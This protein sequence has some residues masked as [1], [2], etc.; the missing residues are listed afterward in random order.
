[1]QD[2]NHLNDLNNAIARLQL[3]EELPEPWNQPGFL[4]E[5]LCLTD[6]IKCYQSLFK[7]LAHLSL[8]VLDE[9][10]NLR[11]ELQ[12]KEGDLDDIKSQLNT[13]EAWIK[14]HQDGLLNQL[15][16]L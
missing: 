1:M 11:Y 4:V 3:A 16:F 7:T 10:E 13:I 14:E 2:L 6:R 12:Q 9:C 5:A 8:E 15:T